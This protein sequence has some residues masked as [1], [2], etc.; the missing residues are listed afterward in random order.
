MIVHADGI[1]FDNNLYDAEADVLYL[2][3]G[4]SRAAADFDE[5]IE[6]HYLRFD[7]DGELMGVTI[8]NARKIIERDGV[9]VVTLPDRTL[10]ITDV[11]DLLAAA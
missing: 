7:K 2:Q 11:G 8:V 10:E 1:R 5:S 9:I 4:E 3:V 6:A